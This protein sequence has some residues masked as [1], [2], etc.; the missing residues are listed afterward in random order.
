MPSVKNLQA[1]Y[2]QLLAQKKKLY[3]DYRKA[4]EEMR[5]LQ[6]AKANVDQILG[7]EIS[8]KEKPHE[9]GRD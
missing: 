3:P 6:I 1:E 5:S 9:Q 2:A 7:T 8:Q 4:K